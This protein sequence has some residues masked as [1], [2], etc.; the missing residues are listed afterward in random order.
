MAVSPTWDSPAGRGPCREILN[1]A[2][3]ISH[4]DA[5]AK[6]LA[7]YEVFAQRRMALPA[8]V[9]AHFQEAIDEAKQLEAARHNKKGTKV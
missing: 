5:V 4:D 2:G 6:A 7:E 1:H 8:P 3:K 9:E